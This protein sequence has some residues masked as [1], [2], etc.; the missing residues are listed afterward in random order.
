MANEHEHQPHPGSIPV[1]L[2]VEYTTNWRTY[3][4]SSNGD[5]NMRSFW[6]NIE[7]IKSILQHNP[8]ADGLRFYMGLSNPA[9]PTSLKIALVSTLNGEDVLVLENGQSNVIDEL[10]PCPPACV[11]GG[12]L[13]NG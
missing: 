9:D 3:L 6:V 12:G 4:S 8:D 2:A 13:L 11:G 10:P 1:D 5:F 7:S